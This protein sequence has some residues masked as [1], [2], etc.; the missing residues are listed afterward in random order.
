MQ[1]TNFCPR[2]DRAKRAEP[3]TDIRCQCD[4]SRT[5]PYLWNIVVISPPTA[6]IA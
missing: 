4:F 1:A 3:D 6:T 2:N 5:V